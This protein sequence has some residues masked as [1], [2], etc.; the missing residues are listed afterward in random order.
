MKKSNLIS[1]F[2]AWISVSL[3]YNNIIFNY[4]L[5]EYI[6]NSGNTYFKILFAAGIVCIMQ[7]TIHCIL[8]VIFDDYSNKIKTIY[9]NKDF[10]VSSI[11]FAVLAIFFVFSDLYY[12]D[13]A[14]YFMMTCMVSILLIP[15]CEYVC[16]GKHSKDLRILLLSLITH[17]KR[18]E[19]M[20]LHERNIRRNIRRRFLKIQKLQGKPRFNLQ[21]LS[22]RMMKIMSTILLL[23]F[24]F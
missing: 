3:S 17:D 18:F 9:E 12:D 22:F 11:I 5:A 7:L 4:Q 1:F 23:Y 6:M 24:F 13:Y 10:K 19:S 21:A 15:G 14:S 2:I 8:L 20:L 16:L